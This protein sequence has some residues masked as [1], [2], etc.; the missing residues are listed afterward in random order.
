MLGGESEV[1]LSG[2]YSTG[3]EEQAKIAKVKPTLEYLEDS[4][5]R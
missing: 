1:S 2:I 3:I 4:H 5:Q